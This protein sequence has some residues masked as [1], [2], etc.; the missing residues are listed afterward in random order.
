MQPLQPSRVNHFS[1]GFQLGLDDGRRFRKYLNVGEG[2]VRRPGRREKGSISHLGGSCGCTEMTSM[3]LLGPGAVRSPVGKALTKAVNRKSSWEVVYMKQL[4]LDH[5]DG[6]TVPSRGVARRRFRMFQDR[7]E[8]RAYTEDQKFDQLA[9]RGYSTHQ[10]L[11]L[12]LT[13]SPGNTETE[14]LGSIARHLSRSSGRSAGTSSLAN[15]VTIC[16]PANTNHKP[17]KEL[18]IGNRP[19]YIVTVTDRVVQFATKSVIEPLVE[20]L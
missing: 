10:L 6:L 4:V 9:E 18:M 7:I 17:L 2:F 20:M 13:G 3:H 8:E 5:E 14:S 12:H 19:V 15:L 1:T 16:R 11:H